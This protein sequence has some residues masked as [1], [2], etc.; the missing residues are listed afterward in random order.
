M[1]ESSL[2][3]FMNIWRMLL[4]VCI[5]PMWETVLL[6]FSTHAYC[7]RVRLFPDSG[8]TVNLFLS[9]C[10]VF[11]DEFAYLFVIRE[12]SEIQ[13]TSGRKYTPIYPVNCSVVVY[14]DLE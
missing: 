8:E 12:V 2:T 5:L 11:D 14:V 1:R 10:P 13:F 6:Y 3:H 4:Y 9:V 7:M